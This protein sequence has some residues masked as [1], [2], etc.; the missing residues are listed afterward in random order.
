MVMSRSAM[1]VNLGRSIRKSLGRYVAIAMII[2]LGASIFV[3]L[4][5]TKRDM[6]AT[7]Q[8]YM[9]AQNMF[10]LRLVS[11]YGWGKDQVDEVRLLE[12]ISDAEGVYYQDLIVSRPS[13]EEAVYRFY[14]IPETVNKLVLLEGRWPENAGECLVDGYRAGSGMIGKEMAISG[15]NDEDALENLTQKSFTVV[16]R[17]STPLYMDMNRGSTS[18]G[19]GAIANCIFVSQD[20]FDVDYYTEIHVTVPGDHRIYSK[21]YNN[22]MDAMADALEPGMEPLA[23]ERYQKVRSDA[24]E[25]YQE[26]WEEYQDG[27]KE[28]A[29]GY[30]EAN[31]RLRDSYRKLTDGEAQIVE[32]EQKLTDG[33]KQLRD[34]RLQLIQGKIT[35]QNGKRALAQGKTE[36]YNQTNQ[37][38]QEMS[39]QLQEKM[40]EL[41]AVNEE[42]D[43][44]NAELAA[45]NAEIAQ[46]EGAMELMD[47]NIGLLNSQIQ[48][49]QTQIDILESQDPSDP[50]LPALQ[51]ALAGLE[52]TREGLITQRDDYET[53]N[54]ETLNELYS[55][56][57]A[58]EEDRAEVESIRDDLAGNASSAEEMLAEFATQLLEMQSQFAAAEAQLSA[59][60]AQ[61]EA[62]EARL[63]MEE[64]NIKTGWEELEKAKQDIQ[65]GWTEYRDGKRD[66]EKE[67][68][69]ARQKLD[70]ARQELMDARADI[71]GMK[72]NTLHIL[73]RNSNIGY[74]SLDSSSDIVEGVSRVFPAFFLLVAALV[75]ITTMTRMVDEERTQIGTLKGLGYSDGAIISKYLFYAGSSAVLGCGLGVLLGSVVFPIILWEA[76][77]IMLFI[78]DSIVLTF[79][80]GLCLL[81]VAVYTGVELLVTWYC[82]HR[83]LKEVPSELIR[84][85]AP[86]AGKPLIF[87]RMR[88]WSRVSF[89]NKVTIRN[90]FRYHQRLAMMLVGIGGCTA[91]LITGFGLR[92]SIVN[93]ADFQ[94]QDV[95]HYDM[96]VYFSEHQD[97]ADQ[98]RFLDKT[99][100]A[101]ENVLF[102][103]QSSVE[104]SFE[105]GLQEIYMISADEGISDFIDFRHG[106]QEI[107]LPGK[108]E[109]VLTS[110]VASALGI[111][112][113]DTVTVR[114]P[115]MESME[116]T[117]FGIYDNYVYNY[118][119]ITPET[120]EE[121]FGQA[122]ERQMAYV[123]VR[124]GQDVHSVGALISGL[125]DVMNVAVS[126]DQADMVH[127]MMDAMNLVVVVIVVCAAALAATVLYN[128]TNININE[129]IREIATIKVLGFNAFETAM[130]IFKE[131]LVLSVLGTGVGML[132][133]KLLLR[134]VMSQ[135]KIN[136]VWFIDRA[137]PISY[138][139]SVVMTLLMAVVVD[140][141]FYFK[142]DKINMAEALKS[143]E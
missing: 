138:I 37:A 120:V 51:A 117:V 9:D 49:I 115:D 2:A 29:D 135:I 56:R 94:F 58:L 118:V 73:D 6:V 34:G 90:I 104:V 102:F 62:S 24:E 41:A 38:V 12:G 35:L 13:D 1:A 33:E 67:L 140:F 5:M 134:F 28:Y 47:S 103:H 27:A 130:Y 107:S 23:K 17:I 42:L 88:L 97:Q 40:D 36:A 72:E 52:S 126:E 108:N 25:A 132:F 142:L 137:L 79:D 8:V 93:I 32:N 65:D 50:N 127:G 11:S 64:Q 95:T 53:E 124:E 84:P 3:G 111:K 121:N 60:E 123:Q 136:M 61:L 74:A 76:Y 87:E 131:N 57:A 133:G 39:E 16:G 110:G 89:L 45:V 86:T 26:G 82:C 18:V 69:E 91:L 139:L 21:D 20:A 10:D 80:W 112:T 54:A 98:K 125:T 122:P 22:A 81:M 119:L 14:T 116:L 66:A 77:K 85:K 48:N 129:R 114:N 71:D 92:D 31:E 44:I 128:L 68:K 78:Q 83:T 19:N 30:H 70:D 99:R 100:D 63:Q 109:A 96:E 15:N 4:R 105:D 59:G 141:V 43:A 75:C 113:G 101:A 106:Q 46:I 55:R 143:V 7:G